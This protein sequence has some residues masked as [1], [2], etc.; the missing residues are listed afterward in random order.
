MRLLNYVAPVVVLLTSRLVLAQ[1]ATEGPLASWDGTPVGAIA[2]LGVTVGVLAWLLW[3]QHQERRTSRE[4][5]LNLQSE[6]KE[7]EQR[8]A[9]SLDDMQ[10]KL[11]QIDR[12]AITAMS[13]YSA[14]TVSLVDKIDALVDKIDVLMTDET[15]AVKAM[16]TRLCALFDPRIDPETREEILSRLGLQ[17]LETHS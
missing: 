15:T 14:A 6:M 16:S 13:S 2:E 8:M 5:R 9:K 3:T 7:R 12:E 1:G 11:L 17:R 4:D 10:N